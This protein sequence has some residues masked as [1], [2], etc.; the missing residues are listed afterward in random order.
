MTTNEQWQAAYLAEDDPRFADNGW[1]LIS[2][3][4]T[5]QIAYP[6]SV[7]GFN[8]WALGDS[9]IGPNFTWRLPNCLGGYDFR[10]LSAAERNLVM[11]A[12]LGS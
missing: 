10:F 7:T 5:N 11:E 2:V 3:K 4:P 6:I 1:I 12:N 8:V 9:M